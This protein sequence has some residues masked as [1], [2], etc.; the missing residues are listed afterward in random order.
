MPVKKK[1]HAVRHYFRRFGTKLA[2]KT[3]LDA[4]SHEKPPKQTT[5]CHKKTSRDVEV[6]LVFDGPFLVVRNAGQKGGSSGIRV[7]RS[8]RRTTKNRPLCHS[9]L[10]GL[11]RWRR[12]LQT[13]PHRVFSAPPPGLPRWSEGLATQRAAS[14]GLLMVLVRRLRNSVLGGDRSS[15]CR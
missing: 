8:A 1:M 7:P 5:P 14:L 6:G 10:P 2:K 13:K 12:G 3:N 4:L 11:S 9:P 15:M